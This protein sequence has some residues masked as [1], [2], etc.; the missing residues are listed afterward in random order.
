MTAS[1]ALSVSNW[2]TSR[3]R[4]APSAKRTEVCSLACRSARQQQVGDVRTSDQQHQ[5]GER[6]EQVQALLVVPGHLGH[7]T[8]RR[9]HQNFLLRDLATV[10]VAGLWSRPRHYSAIAA[11]R[12]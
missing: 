9:N 11:V 6:H 2:R 12:P 1:N 7:A 3:A 8:G 10:T 5:S 4:R